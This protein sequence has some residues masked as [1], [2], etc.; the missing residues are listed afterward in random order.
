M[1]FRFFTQNLDA[2]GRTIKKKN[3]GELDDLNQLKKFEMGEFLGG[4]ENASEIRKK[5]FF[6]GLFSPAPCQGE[7]PQ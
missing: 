7:L 4:N 1:N 3:L 5:G 2:M 6:S